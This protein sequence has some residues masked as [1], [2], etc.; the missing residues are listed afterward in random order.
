MHAV[1]IL[2]CSDNKYYTGCTSNLEKRLVKHRN[3]QVN[4]TKYRLPIELETYIVTSLF[5]PQNM[6]R[7]HP[8]RFD[9]LIAY[10]N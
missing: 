8:C 1:N 10:S 6:R 4:S 7:I 2:L 3:G 5:I 9:G